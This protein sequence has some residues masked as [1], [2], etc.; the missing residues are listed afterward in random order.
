MVG[1]LSPVAAVAAL[2]Q[3][4]NERLKCHKTLRGIRIVLV[5]TLLKPEWYRWFRWVVDFWFTIPAGSNPAWPRAMQE[6]LTIGVY[7]PLLHHRP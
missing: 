1:S 3:L 4:D 5:P 6:P 7:L 2:E